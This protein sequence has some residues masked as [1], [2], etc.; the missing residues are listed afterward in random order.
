MPSTPVP[1]GSGLP[2][3]VPTAM[4]SALGLAVENWRS[5]L[6]L[7]SIMVSPQE[8]ARCNLCSAMAPLPW[9]KSK[10]RSAAI[11]TR[12]CTCA[13]AG[14]LRGRNAMRSAKFED[15]HAPFALDRG[16]Q[17]ASSVKT[18]RST[19]ADL[20]ADFFCL[21]R[22]LAAAAPVRTAA[23]AA[24]RRSG[25]EWL[26]KSRDA[27]TTDRPEVFSGNGAGSNNALEQ[28]IGIATRKWC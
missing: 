13:A 27:S 5:I 1:T 18:A 9:R 20:R 17:H 23:N 28:H 4:T 3:I 14:V 12:A 15:Q 6:E 21:S 22:T 26:S 2:R 19:G 8:S 10:G 11:L 24:L 25:T 16:R 7:V